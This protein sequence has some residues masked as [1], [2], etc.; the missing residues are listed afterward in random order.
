[1]C[2]CERSNQLGILFE[3]TDSYF[4]NNYRPPLSP[5]KNPIKREK[6]KLVCSSEREDFY[7]KRGEPVCLPLESPRNVFW[8]SCKTLPISCN[9]LSI[10]CNSLSISCNSLSI[11][12]SARSQTASPSLGRALKKSPFLRTKTEKCYDL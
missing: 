10:S 3:N 7:L 11:S 1:M 12:F 5:P 8:M 4:L 2:Y 9:S 6:K